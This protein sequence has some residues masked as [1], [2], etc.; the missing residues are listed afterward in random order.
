LLDN[1]HQELFWE[2]MKDKLNLNQCETFE[3]LKPEIDK[4][5]ECYNNEGYQWDIMK[6]VPNKYYVYLTTS[7]FHIKKAT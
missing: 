4:Y 2:Y 7:I 6:M 1:A 3:Q 5:I